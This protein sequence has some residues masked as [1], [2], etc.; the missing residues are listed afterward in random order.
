MGGKAMKK[1][2]VGCILIAFLTAPVAL[3]SEIFHHGS[4][5][6]YFNPDFMVNCVLAAP[7]EE[8]EC[9]LVLSNP[10]TWEEVEFLGWEMIVEI[11]GPHEV[12]QW[13]LPENAFNLFQPPEFLVSFLDGPIPYSF[14][15]QLLTITVLVTGTETIT[16]WTRPLQLPSCWPENEPHY[17]TMVGGWEPSCDRM[18]PIT[19]FDA[20]GNWNPVAVINGDCVLEAEDLTWGHLKSLYR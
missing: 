19:G 3:A 14:H 15:N 2:A 6:I 18:N 12:T 16:F 13:S 4:I 9:Y 7:G 10:L 17:H 5:G 11:D 8:V 1:V 20:E